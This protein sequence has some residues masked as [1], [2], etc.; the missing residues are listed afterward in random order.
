MDFGIF[1]VMQ[2][3]EFGCPIAAIDVPQAAESA[4]AD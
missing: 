3:R 4:A 1:N 2:Q